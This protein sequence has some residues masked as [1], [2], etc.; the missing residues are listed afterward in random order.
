[1]VKSNGCQ[2]LRAGELATIV[3]TV[4]SYDPDGDTADFFYA[5][6]A[7]NPDGCILVALGLQY[8]VLLI[9]K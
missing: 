5:A 4:Y 1:M 7:S 8:S 2:E 9:L 3:A 6:N